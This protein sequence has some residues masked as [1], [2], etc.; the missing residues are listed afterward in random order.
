MVARPSCGGPIEH[1]I[2]MRTLINLGRI[3]VA[4][5]F[6][7]GPVAASD[8]SVF[9]DRV[10]AFIELSERISAGGE[11]DAVSRLENVYRRYFDIARIAERIA[12][13]P[14]WLK[15]N[16]QQ[17]RRFT[18]IVTCRLAVESLKRANSEKHISW[19]VVGSRSAARGRTV[20]VRFIL[21]ENRQRTVLFDVVPSASGIR[22]V[23]IR[24]GAGRLS[25]RF[26]DQLVRETRN[27]A[28]PSDPKRWLNAVECRL[29]GQ[30][31]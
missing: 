6:L 4:A 16:K 17:K 29:P 5:L 22:V 14:F 24:S 1:I 11:P 8:D 3:V 27:I 25:V 10:T 18:G 20:A 12:P 9:A 19:K 21:P 26:A 15:A 31:K 30:R 2:A 7:S 28:D 13:E 23:D